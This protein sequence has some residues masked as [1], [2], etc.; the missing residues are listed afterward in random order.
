LIELM[1]VVATLSIVAVVAVPAFVKYMKPMESPPNP[2]TVSAAVKK[3]GYEEI[4]MGVCKAPARDFGCT[5]ADTWACPFR[6]MNALKRNV[7]L[8][9]CTG[10]VGSNQGVLIRSR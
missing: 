4:Q 1:I 6:A 5:Q 3:Q 2:V 8:I 10:P 7:D 9:A